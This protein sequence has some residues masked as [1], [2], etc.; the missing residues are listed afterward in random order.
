[1]KQKAKILHIDDSE[2]NR[3][4]VRHILEN[5]GY[6]VIEAASGDKGLKL[7]EDLP[8]LIVLDIRLPDTN[9]FEVCRKI[10]A[11]PRTTHI[12]VLQT[13]AMFTSSD[14]KVEGLE[15]G[16]DG[17][18]AQP[19]EGAV[20]VATVRS[21][22]R[23]RAAEGEAQ[24][25]T[26]ARDEMMAIVSHDLR[27]PLSAIMLQVKLLK[28][29]YEEKGE[30]ADL[31]AKLDRI[32]NSCTRMN[33]LIQDLLDVSSMEGGKFNITKNPFSASDLVKETV[34]N[35][36]E[37]AEQK[38]IALKLSIAQN[39]SLMGDR[40]RIHQ[41]LLNLISNSLKFTNEKGSV[42][43]SLKDEKDHS[44]FCVQ[45]TG[46]GIAPEFLPHI[47]DR[48]WQGHMEKRDGVGLGLSIVKGIIE[49]HGGSINVESEPGKGT[50]ICFT[51]PK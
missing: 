11:N 16:A 29:V 4:A 26:Q 47:F 34:S 19:I 30:V 14:N 44:L 33:R 15:S 22:L 25:A 3:Y 27:N 42:S 6:E 35:F 49:A 38:S 21:L 51:L 43:V 9:G 36:E 17:Y 41:V 10:K 18:L 7:S 1:M 50:L 45:D 48:Y 12:P 13:S 23:I 28:K 8:D 24:R 37:L 40:E 46:K 5:A 31:S 20:L 32:G 39:V 2:A